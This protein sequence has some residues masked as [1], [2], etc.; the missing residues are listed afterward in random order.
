[1]HSVHISWDQNLDC[2]FPSSIDRARLVVAPNWFVSVQ[3]LEIGA[4]N[5]QLA[6]SKWMKVRAIDLLSRDTKVEQKDFFHV[7]VGSGPPGELPNT[8]TAES[9]SSSSSSA[10]SSAVVLAASVGASS[11]SGRDRITCPTTSRLHEV[12]WDTW[13]EKDK[14][15]AAA[16]KGRGGGMEGK[17]GKKRQRSGDGNDDDDEDD[18]NEAGHDGGGAAG[19]SSSAVAVASSRRHASP[20]AVNVHINCPS[21]GYTVPVCGGYDVVVNAMV[22]NCVMDPIQRAEM[23]VKCRDH[24]VPGGLF[25]LALPSRCIDMSG[26]ITRKMFEQLLRIIGEF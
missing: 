9:A 19:A 8:S 12:D 10:S 21:Q 6:V 7:P 23:L 26:Y 4:V 22:V 15:A 1:M 20:A 17:I 5:G 14:A 2:H 16:A 13:A 3:V 11:F 25:Y 18:E 24:L